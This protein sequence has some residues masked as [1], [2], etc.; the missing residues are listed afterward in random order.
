MQGFIDFILRFK[1]YISFAALIV[2]SL[3]LISMG[4]VNKIGGFRTIVI[5]T[6][7]WFQDVFSWIPNP[8]AIK[9]ENIAL[10]ELNLQLSSE[11]TRMRDAVVENRNLRAMLGYAQKP[12][13]PIETVEIVGTTSI[14]MRTYL[15]INKGTSQG[16]KTGMSVRTDAGLV[17]VLIGVGKNYSLIEMIMNRDVR[18]SAKCL[19]SG[20]KGIIAWE[21]GENLIMK[22][23]PKSYDIKNGDVIVTSDFSNKYPE[24]I[25]IGTVIKS[26]EQPG[27]LFLNVVVRPLVNFS[28]IEQAFVLKILPDEEKNLLIEELDRKLM[29]RNSEVKRNEK[30][31]FK[32]DKKQKNTGK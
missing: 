16:L 5:G 19:R 14:Q 18:V 23:V 29:L 17:G 12:D 24:N 30:L 10:R 7:G 20:Y 3:S 32:T 4:S 11:V 28:T 22:N 9:N 2:I 31:I 27:N 13:Y 6:M 25:P 8:A 21:G 1:N 26:K 15:M